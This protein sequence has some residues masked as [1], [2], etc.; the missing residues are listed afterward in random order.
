MINYV[1]G[2]V[3]VDHQK[4][5]NDY[6]VGGGISELRPSEINYFDWLGLIGVSGAV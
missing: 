6:L 5:I 1:V 3:N 4:L 2:S